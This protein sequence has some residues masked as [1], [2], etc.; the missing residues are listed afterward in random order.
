MTFSDGRTCFN[1]HPFAIAIYNVRRSASEVRSQFRSTLT[2][3]C[4]VWSGLS[5]MCT[6]LS[7]QVCECV[8]GR[9]QFRLRVHAKG[10]DGGCN[11]RSPQFVQWCA[12]VLYTRN[13]CIRFLLRAQ[14]GALDAIGLCVVEWT[15]CIA[16][17]V[18][19][20][21]RYDGVAF[22]AYLVDYGQH[23][24][25]IVM[26]VA[27]LPGA[28]A[29]CSREMCNSLSFSF[30]R[31]AQMFARSQQINA[32]FV[33]IATFNMSFR[34]HLR[35]Q[36]HLTH[37]CFAQVSCMLF[38]ASSAELASICRW[39]VGRYRRW[40]RSQES[41]TT[42]QCC[43]LCAEQADPVERLTKLF[44]QCFRWEQ[45]SLRRQRWDKIA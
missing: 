7:A 29:L 13:M 9:K 15:Y 26:I 41:Q 14:W 18:S 16:T 24:A 21:C 1:V 12:G 31:L 11:T 19:Y 34:I 27:V 17:S 30:I 33:T 43:P 10:D 45:T 4:W 37:C 42:I 40:T 6:C 3:E 28:F 5:P 23:L 35:L 22:E 25:V 32:R 44:V 20:C 36:C 39:M 38:I 2:F 8:W